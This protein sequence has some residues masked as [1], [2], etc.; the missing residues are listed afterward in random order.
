M[1]R[2]L[3][4]KYFINPICNIVKRE[5]GAYRYELDMLKMQNGRIL[6]NQMLSNHSISTIHNAEF[7]VFSQW[8]DDGIIQYL[9]HKMGIKNKTFIEFGVQDYLESNTRFLLL[10]NNWKGLII[11][12]SE[13][14]M[15]SVKEDAMYWRHDLTAVCAFITVENIDSL[16]ANN[17]F[18]DNIGILSIDIDGNDYWVWEKITSVDS[19]IVIVEYNSLFGCKHAV[20]VPYNPSFIRQ[21]AHYSYLYWGCSLKALYNLALTKG[22]IFVGCNSNG[23]N[24]Y[25]IKK[26]KAKELKAL[27]VEEGY[28]E[29]MFRESRAQDGRLNFTSGSKRIKL[30]EDMPVVDVEKNKTVLLK[31]LL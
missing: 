9:V 17:E 29:S 28:V 25:F 2:N 14:Y 24:A 6:C 15:N 23:T 5:L 30:I 1:F 26:E 20:T 10:N 11:D 18:K 8:G 12:S 22:Y 3:Y 31:E 13:Q 19:D 4:Q 27:T 7:K 16:F 21:E